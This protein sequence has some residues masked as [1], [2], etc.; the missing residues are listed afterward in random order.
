MCHS[1]NH[2]YST[3]GA[4]DGQITLPRPKSNS[5]K[6]AAFYRSTT[7]WNSLPNELRQISEKANFKRKLNLYMNSQ[8]I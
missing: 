5:M 8:S 2:S 1:N 7:L 6:R 3:R 4:S